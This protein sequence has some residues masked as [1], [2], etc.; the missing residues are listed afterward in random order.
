MSRYL[1]NLLARTFEPSTA[2]VQPRLNALFAPPETNS[3]WSSSLFTAAEYGVAEESTRVDGKSA[4]SP[5][6]LLPVPNPNLT[7]Q[8]EPSPS[9]V[10]YA[11]AP[12]LGVPGEHVAST[13]NEPEDVSLNRGSEQGERRHTKP[14]SARPLVAAQPPQSTTAQPMQSTTAQPT[15]AGTT[16]SSALTASEGQFEKRVKS[17][18][19]PYV[20]GRPAPMP[21]SARAELQGRERSA[22]RTDD[23]GK[24]TKKKPT[25]SAPAAVHID[26]AMAPPERAAGRVPDLVPPPLDHIEPLKTQIEK[27]PV[28]PAC[29]VFTAAN[30]E[31]EMLAEPGF[32]RSR[33]AETRVSEARVGPALNESR[34]QRAPHSI[35]GVDLHLRDRREAESSEPTIEVTIGRIEVRGAFPAES[36]RAVSQPAPG[37]S[38]VEYLRRRSGRSRE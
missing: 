10:L 6:D 11:A 14:Y 33:L 7:H 17:G 27:H 22:S 8:T 37:A 15:V 16:T 35:R 26:P 19:K 25:V 34:F 29:P 24:P 20:Q 38:L 9:P 21:S 2:M 36:H 5:T 13:E 3:H 12:V 28:V 1:T 18:R 32:G 4:S 31:T 23:G 30:Q